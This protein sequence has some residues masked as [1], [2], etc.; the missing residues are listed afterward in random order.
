MLLILLALGIGREALATVGQDRVV[1]SS[2]TLFIA[3]GGAIFQEYLYRYARRVAR[4]TGSAALLATA[5]RLPARRAGERGR[6]LRSLAGGGG[7]GD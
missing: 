7:L 5:W 6:R 1:P 4:E 3:M 2:Y